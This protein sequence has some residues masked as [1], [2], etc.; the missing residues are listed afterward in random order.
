M[1]RRVARGDVRPR[2]ARCTIAVTEP[3]PL[4][5]A[6]MIELEGAFGMVERGAEPRDVLEAELHA[7]PFE[8]EEVAERIRVQL[9]ARPRRLDGAPARLPAG[10]RTAECA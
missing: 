3:L 6:T 2:A 9:L 1:R 5:P 7:Q 10:R 8:A 4:V